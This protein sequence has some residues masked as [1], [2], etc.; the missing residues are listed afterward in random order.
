MRRPLNMWLLLVVIICAAS[1]W[2]GR[3]V[4]IPFLESGPGG[5]SGRGQGFTPAGP[6][7]PSIHLLILNGTDLGGLARDVSRLVTRAGWVAENI[8][9]APDDHHPVSLLINRRLDRETAL[10][11][12]QRLGGLPLLEEWDGRGTEDAVLLLG[13]DHAAVVATLGR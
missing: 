11:L 12:A 9:N 8:G 4:R 2:A 7:I 3:G 13:K 6:E 1:F 5:D 10:N